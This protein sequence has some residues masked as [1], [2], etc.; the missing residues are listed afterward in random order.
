VIDEYFY[1]S[2]GRELKEAAVLIPRAR[3]FFGDNLEIYTGKNGTGTKLVRGSD[4]ILLNPFVPLINTNNVEFY[5]GIL[6]LNQEMTKSLWVSY[7]TLGGSFSFDERTTLETLMGMLTGQVYYLWSQIKNKP[8]T[9]PPRYHTHEEDDAPMPALVA[10]LESMYINVLASV[11]VVVNPNPGTSTPTPVPS[12]STRWSGMA[13]GSNNINSVSEGGTAYLIITAQNIALGEKVALSY[14]GTATVPDFV[15]TLPTFATIGSYNGGLGVAVPFNA[16]NDFLL[17]GTENLYVTATFNTASTTSPKLDILDTSVPIKLQLTAYDSQGNVATSIKPG[18]TINYTVV[19]TSRAL[20][21]NAQIFITTNIDIVGSNVLDLSKY[22]AAQ[23][24]ASINLSNWSGS[25]A[26]TY[27]DNLPVSVKSAAIGVG[28]TLEAAQQASALG[29]VPSALLPATG[30]AS[31]L[32]TVLPAFDAYFAAPSGAAVSSLSADLIGYY[33]VASAV[34]KDGAKYSVGIS[35]NGNVL[36]P[37]TNTSDVIT[38][39]IPAQVTFSGGKAYFSLSFNVTKFTTSTDVR[40]WLYEATQADVY[41]A[42]DK[43]LSVTAPS[44]TYVPITAASWSAMGGVTS[45]DTYN[46]APISVLRSLNLWSYF[47]NY[48]GRVPSAGEKIKFT[49]AANVAIVGTFTTPAIEVGGAD[50]AWT[51]QNNITIACDGLIFGMGGQGFWNGSSSSRPSTDGH[52]AINNNT[53]A[54]LTVAKSSTGWVAGGGGGG[55][56]RAMMLIGPQGG[57]GA[58]YAG[59]AYNNVNP[60]SLTV[61]DPGSGNGSNAGG[62]PGMPGKGTAPVRNPGPISTGTGTVVVINV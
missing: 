1:I 36:T 48:T 7:N 56:S 47:K 37:G 39:V 5:Y 50:S 43:T 29:V 24:P 21:A 20:A 34:V 35:V 49:L 8:L 40:C 61:P 17:E 18:D 4:Y 46:S 32:P 57:G 6:I 19:D 12:L 53:Q 22:L 10:Q 15:G 31:I 16:L 55:N 51:A 33:N 54:T 13:D 2:P 25:F 62:A 41:Q 44:I 30:M 9:Y 58:P 3:P 23:P 60:A 26:L 38:G 52:P 14:A 27:K 42:S 11:P 45:T 28:T 59:S